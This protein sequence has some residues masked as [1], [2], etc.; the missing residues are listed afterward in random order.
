ML[1][2]ELEKS[3]AMHIP[4][5]GFIC[6]C[7][8]LFE[9]SPVRDFKELLKFE[10]GESVFK[11]IYSDDCQ[12]HE[13]NGIISIL[14]GNL[15]HGLH[16]DS[17]P[18]LYKKYDIETGKHL[19]G[20]YAVLILDRAKERAVIISD[21]VSSKP[22]YFARWDNSWLVSTSFVQLTR[23]FP[24]EQELDPAGV[25]WY[26]SNGVIHNSHTLFREVKRLERATLYSGD[27]HSFTSHEYWK[28]D[29]HDV[30]EPGDEKALINKMKE[31][32]TAAVRDCLPLNEPVYLSLSGGFDSSG[33]LAVMKYPLN[34]KDVRTFSYG[35]SDDKPFSDPAL[36]R[37]LAGIA[38]YDH[39]LQASYDNDFKNV[40]E[41]NAL[42]GDGISN[43]CDEVTAWQNFENQFGDQKPVCFFG[44]TIF[45]DGLYDELNDEK[46]A[47]EAILIRDMDYL[48][49]LER[50]I[51]QET[52]HHLSQKLQ[53]EC[54]KL[55]EKSRVAS[56]S[57]YDQVNYL[58]LE[59]R[60]RVAHVPWRVNFCSKAFIPINPL[61]HD[62]CLEFQKII[63][64][65]FRERKNLFINAVKDLAPDFYQSGRARSMGYVP[66]WKAEI[67]RNYN[68]ILEEYLNNQASHQ[69][70]AFI[71][72]ES[73]IKMIGNEIMNKPAAIKRNTFSS[74]IKKL[75]LSRKSHKPSS[76]ARKILPPV[77]FILRYLVLK[78]TL[79][80]IRD[81]K[82]MKS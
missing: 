39:F 52:Y 40:L 7:E 13:K 4:F 5:S 55:L 54:R 24:G 37:E 2:C 57:L 27:V 63:P 16:P 47:L 80:I 21:R 42:W 48:P 45:A 44:D 67:T 36:A 68:M 60:A 15:F 6:L 32:L 62:D 58:V 28:F 74:L 10:L 20:T 66:D 81:L 79:E 33:L 65:E 17:I 8:P 34:L 61:Y 9:T 72:T 14:W 77:K 76:P 43:F 49:W 70:D 56:Q 53:E 1:I 73:V 29:F 75:P 31:V 41:L 59:D 25:A 64:Q 69:L 23:Y 38:G 50:Y 12:V 51:P 82:T 78:R 19:S 3:T 30:A 22:A 11:V 35:L 71:S 26:L 46:D 18:D